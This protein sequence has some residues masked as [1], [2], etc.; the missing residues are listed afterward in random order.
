M[1]KPAIQNIRQHAIGHVK[2]IRRA[3][4]MQCWAFAVGTDVENGG[5][6]LD[7]FKL[8]H[9]SAVDAHLGHMA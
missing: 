6:C 1:E 3:T 7:T 4:A 9:L 2:M 8:L 5:R